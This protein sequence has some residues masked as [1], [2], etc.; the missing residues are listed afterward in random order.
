M[1]VNFEPPRISKPRKRQDRFILLKRNDASEFY[2]YYTIK[3]QDSYIKRKLK[4]ERENFPHLEVLLDLNCNDSK[5]LY[6]KLKD[7]LKTKGVIF[8]GNNIDLVET[9]LTEQDLINAM[10]VIDNSQ[11]QQ[12]ITK[13]I[14]C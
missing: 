5:L 10:R 2:P 9:D 7:K 12:A 11:K 13:S 4:V 1:V 8:K 3:A 6:F 14:N